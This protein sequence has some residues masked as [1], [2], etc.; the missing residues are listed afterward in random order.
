MQLVCSVCKQKYELTAQR[1]KCDCGAPLN[2]DQSFSFRVSDIEKDDFSLWRYRNFLPVENSENIVSLGEGMTPLHPLKNL[3]SGKLYAKLEYMSATGSFKDR[4]A[5]VMISKLKEMNVSKLVEDS[6]GNSACSIAA[7]AAS[8]GMDAHIFVPFTNSKVKFAQL[9]AYHACICSVP[10]SRKDCAVAAEK[11][12]QDMCYASHSWNPFFV[13]GNKTFFYETAEQ[14]DWKAPDYIFIAVGSGSLLLGTWLAIRELYQAR[15]ID[16]MPKLIAVQ[17]EHC[18]PV[19]E[20][21]EPGWKSIA[22]PRPALAEG[23]AVAAPPRLAEIVCAVRSSGGDFV[24][25]SDDEIMDA[26]LTLAK[27]GLFVE[28]TS[29]SVYAAFM[30]CVNQIGQDKTVVLPLTGSG[31]KTGMMYY[32]YFSAKNI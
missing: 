19:R 17:S 32:D 28:P 2:L 29:A 11:A 25:V 30:R 21:M 6:S 4:G 12:A 26:A 18:A 9:H 24:T 3:Y 20:S 15:V 31:L 27:N 16:H 1:Y 7:Y 13:Q 23:I 8:A 10:G 14:L 5:S 22:S